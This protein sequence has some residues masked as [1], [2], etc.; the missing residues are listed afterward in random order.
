MKGKFD[1]KSIQLNEILNSKHLIKRKRR[2]LKM[3]EKNL[4]LEA[5]KQTN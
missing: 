4:L 1:Y 5:F 2:S 3:S